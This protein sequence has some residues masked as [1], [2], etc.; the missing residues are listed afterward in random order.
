ML[1]AEAELLLELN[2]T[3]IPSFMSCKIVDLAVLFFRRDLT[4]DR[5]LKSSSY[6]EGQVSQSTVYLSNEDYQEGVFQ[7]MN[8][9]KRYRRVSC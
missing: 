4:V 8:S 3:Q 9:V 5:G 7:V 2:L 6:T 1:D